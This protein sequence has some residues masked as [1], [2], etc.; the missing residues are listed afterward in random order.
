MIILY[1]SQN[2]RMDSV[3]TGL[4]A[5]GWKLNWWNIWINF[6]VFLSFDS[7]QLDKNILK[8]CLP[9]T[10]TMILKISIIPEEELRNLVF[11]E[12]VALDFVLLLLTQA[13]LAIYIS[14]LTLHSDCAILLYAKKL[15]KNRKW[16]CLQI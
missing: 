7:R 12:T 3:W 15:E 1:S 11:Y 4:A 8:L 10:L 9:I 16:N 14:L 2:Q 5:I 6:S 13:I